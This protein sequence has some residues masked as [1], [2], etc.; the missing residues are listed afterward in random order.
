M[1]WFFAVWFLITFKARV[2]NVQVTKINTKKTV[3]KEHFF[4]YFI[5]EWE[6]LF[7]WWDECSFSHASWLVI[8]GLYEVLFGWNFT[9]LFN[10]SLS[11]LPIIYRKTNLISRKWELF[12][13]GC[14]HFEVIRSIWVHLYFVFMVNRL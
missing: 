13:T 7:N 2:S 8:T 10:D 12:C 6:I 14:N 5:L 1:R 4:A 11:L 3:V 9:Q